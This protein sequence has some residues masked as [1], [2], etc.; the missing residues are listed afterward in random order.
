MLVDNPSNAI[1]DYEHIATANGTGSSG[2]ITFSSIPQK[3]K[4]LQVIY[5]AKNTA[6][7]TNINITMNGITTTS[8]VRHSLLGNGS[9]VS[10]TNSGT[11][12]PS[13][14]LVEAM[15]TSTTTGLVAS[16]IIDIFDYSNTS[17]NTVISAI[18]G[19]TTDL[20]RIYLSGGLFVNTAA[21]TSITLTASGSNFSNLTSFSLYGILG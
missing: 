6:G 2:V 15:A 3:Y 9:A 7:S 1:S 12:R 21:V 4:N 10:S 8:Y 20:N 13:I 16:G 14:E 11:S 18:Y 17:K 19:Q 5:T